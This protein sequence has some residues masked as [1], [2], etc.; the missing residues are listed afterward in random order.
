MNRFKVYEKDADFVMDT[1]SGA[2]WLVK[3]TSPRQNQKIHTPE[4]DYLAKLLVGELNIRWQLIEYK[5]RWAGKERPVMIGETMYHVHYA[6]MRED[7]ITF[8]CRDVCMAYW[9]F[10]N[11]TV[12]PPLSGIQFCLKCMDQE[13]DIDGRAHLLL[14]S[15]FE[16]LVSERTKI[17]EE[18]R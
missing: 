3:Q 6:K 8:A 13:G 17:Q 4:P 9:T 2:M 1:K 5:A 18:K 14:R 7:G 15:E 11:L 16:A 10:K 12:Y